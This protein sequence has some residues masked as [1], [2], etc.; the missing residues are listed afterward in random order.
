MQKM[1]RLGQR[2]SPRRP[3][4]QG[5]QMSNED[6]EEFECWL[7]NKIDFESAAMPAPAEE[8]SEAPEGWGVITV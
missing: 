4:R 8:D 3:G 1:Q 5:G 7:P 6:W 2:P